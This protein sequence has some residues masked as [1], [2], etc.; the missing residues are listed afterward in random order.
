MKKQTTVR[1]EERLLKGV[2]RFVDG[3]RYRSRAHVIETALAEF[4]ENNKPP[5]KRR[6]G[7]K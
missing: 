6:R 1:I 4:L 7:T 5:A 2:D 3:A